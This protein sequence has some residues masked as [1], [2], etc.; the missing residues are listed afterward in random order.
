[1]QITRRVYGTKDPYCIVVPIE[2]RNPLCY[3]LSQVQGR[4][5]VEWGETVRFLGAAKPMI[6][7]QIAESMQMAVVGRVDKQLVCISPLIMVPNNGK[8][9]FRICHD[10]RMLNAATTK[11]W[12]PA[13]DRT[14]RAQR[15]HGVEFF[16]VLDLTKGFMQIS[17]QKS[18][19]KYFGF[20]FDGS[21]FCFKRLLFSF[22]K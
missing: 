17:I 4:S 10:L 20:Y 14:A 12:G 2:M 11:E 6:A 18:D 7:G 21:F 16:S 1:M 9:R 5:P 15:I 8:P 22:C 3:S 19:Q 13:M